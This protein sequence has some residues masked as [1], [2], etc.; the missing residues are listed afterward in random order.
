MRKNSV[1][2]SVYSKGFLAMIRDNFDVAVAT[3]ICRL[4]NEYS[5]D[6]INT[7]PN[8]YG[9]AIKVSYPFAGVYKA[10]QKYVSKEEALQMMKNNTG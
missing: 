7:H 9:S 6:Y 1:N 3:D 10:L 5:D 4:A 8:A 2:K